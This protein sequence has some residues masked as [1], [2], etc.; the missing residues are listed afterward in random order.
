MRFAVAAEGSG[1]SRAS[2]FVAIIFAVAFESAG[3][4]AMTEGEQAY[5]GLRELALKISPDDLGLKLDGDGIAA[6]GVLMEF[7][8]PKATV[9]LT[10]YSSGD[11]SLYFSTGG[12]VIGG[13]GHETVRSA[14]RQ[15]VSSAQTFLNKMKEVASFPLPPT[16]VTH[17]YVL[18]N[19]GIYCSPELISDDLRNPASEF[20]ALFAAGQDVITEI[21]KTK[22]Q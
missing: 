9:T 4:H 2:L 10:S 3:T 12:G 1:A 5:K 21:R 11:A 7:T 20:F 18:T 17:F 16:G 6:H 13:V 14:A 19:H 22:T 15:F 8:L